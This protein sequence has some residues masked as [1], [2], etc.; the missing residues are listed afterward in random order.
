ML[1]EATSRLADFAF[2]P[3]ESETLALTALVPER[4]RDPRLAL[5]CSETQFDDGEANFLKMTAFEVG[6]I[7][8]G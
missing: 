8:E 6:S 5:R 3:G 1:D 7:T 4:L 2:Q